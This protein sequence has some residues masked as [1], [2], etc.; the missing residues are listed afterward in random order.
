MVL[1]TEKH[2]SELYGVLNSY[3]RIVIAGHLQP[4]SYAKGM[5]KYLY[6]EGIRIFDY[7]GFAQ[8]LRELV[9]ANAEQIAQE[10]GVEIEFVTKH[11]QMRKEARIQQ[12]LEKR[13]EHAGLVHILSAMEAC[14][15]YMPWHDKQSGKTYVKTTQGKC[16]HYYFYFIDETLGLCYLRVPTWSPFRLQFYCNGHNWLASQLRRE[17]ITFVQ[18][19]NAFLQIGDFDRANE[20]AAALNVTELQQ[21]LDY[22]AQL[23]CPV[24]GHLKLVY[25]WSL[26]Q[27]EYATDLVFKAQ[28]SLQAFYPHLLE[29]LIQAVK[30]ADIATFLGRKLHS[31]YQDEMG[32]HLQTRIEGTRIRHRM[33]PV[34]IKMYD[35]F[36]IV[37]RI[38][39]TVAD[40]SFFQ[41]RR[42]VHHRNGT[43]SIEWT[44][45]R[46]SIYSLPPL[47]EQLTAANH[48]YLHFISAIDTPDGGSK[49]LRKL[50]ETKTD[51]QRRYKGFHL[52]SEEDSLL[53][54]TLLRGEF[55]IQGFTNQT[56]RQHLSLN[57]GQITRLLKRL[58]VHGL[59]KRT[60]RHY[61]YYLTAFG[62]QAA[63]IALKLREMV[64]IP[65]FAA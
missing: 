28:Q 21:Q 31:N 40:V 22:F 46:K 41:Q 11:S 2:E 60:G 33:G 58:R 7:Q 52:F 50:T 26:M 32:N 45:M 15:A 16:L 42:Q 5:T 43:T 49:K 56:L 4:L 35:K 63:I 64:I 19:D 57:A 38:E 17:E 53:F 36:G 23:Y 6:Q 20:I 34:A 9:R 55:V 39:T 1:L 14:T 27:V 12:I 65:A 61:K 62:R 48:R 30:P 18:H 44:K 25:S 3:D 29:T 47:Q 13:G 37:L 24:V 51:K 8:P 59:I 54:R 10:N